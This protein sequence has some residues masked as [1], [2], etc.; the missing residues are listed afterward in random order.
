MRPMRGTPAGPDAELLADIRRQ[1]RARPNPARA[2]Q[3]AAYMKVALPFIGLAVPEVRR[4][5]KTS[6]R[7]HP[8]ATVAAY[9]RFLAEGF[10]RAAYQEERYAALA[11][12]GE[13]RCLPF[14]GAALMP[15]YRRLI[16]AGRWWDVVDD[17]SCRVGEALVA[18]PEPVSKTLLLW[19]RGKDIWL[20][21]A[22]IICQRK[23][24]ARTDTPLLFACIAPSLGEP[25]FF[26]RK[27]IGW[28]LR[29]LAYQAPDEVRRY[30][31][32]HAPQLSPLSQKE[33][34]RR[35]GP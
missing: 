14:Q 19:A 30:V 31:R 2:A 24:A 33:A 9:R 29:S 28:A 23:L 11:V 5:A 18:E 26:L 25:E 4:I 15:L 22:A 7:A 16:V 3:A 35:I 21:R 17:L 27:A 32:A 10:L 12:A 20:R 1:L 6:L 13:R 8:L 34:L